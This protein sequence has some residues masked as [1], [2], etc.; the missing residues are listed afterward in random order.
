MLFKQFQHSLFT[1]YFC[2]FF[3]NIF[4]N[5]VGIKQR[6]SLANRTTVMKLIF[7]AQ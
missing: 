3:N 6:S 4:Y 2:S 7:F 5:S 1:V